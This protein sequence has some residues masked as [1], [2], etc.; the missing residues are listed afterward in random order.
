L[1]NPHPRSVISV[2][3]VICPRC[4]NSAPFNNGHRYSYGLEIQRFKC[5]KCGYRFSDPTALKTVR[6]NKEISQ[7]NKLS[8][9]LALATLENKETSA[10]INTTQQ[11]LIFEYQWKM[12][13][14]QLA[15]TTIYNRSIWLAQLVNYGADL[16]NPET[17]E[18]VLATEEIPAATK[19]NII[20][21]YATFVKA[22]K[23]SWEKPRNK[24]Q[25]KQAFDPLEEEIDL[26]I[27]A[28]GRITAAFLQVLKD[29]GARAGEAR[30]IQ[31]TD[32]N[33]K[34]HT[35][36]INNAEKGSNNRTVKI[37]EKTISMLKNL[38]KKN[39]EYI[40][41]PKCASMR[42]SFV[43]KRK[44]LALKTQNPRLLKI[45][46]HTF[47]HWRASREYEKTGDIYA[48]KNLLGHKSIIN[49]D[50]YQHGSFSSEEY[51][52][53]RPKTS[54]EEDN[55][56]NAGFEYVRF[57]QKEDCPIYRKRK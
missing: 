47:R 57:D 39:G 27:N 19:R 26:L 55:L 11:G 35:I 46:F 43:N 29:T 30:K 6:D 49:T 53:K 40:F 7:Q 52:T 8:R 41:S 20:N 50:R 37:T 25:P 23:L 31:W 24:Y 18:T 33:E 48:V 28:S 16:K 54:I 3:S 36:D 9:G 5:K 2:I 1:R 14:R 32:I 51:I 45:H 44:E 22:F 34:N 13:K 21:T 56:I 42:Q 17:V 10:G 15:K 38:P 4:G 12:Q